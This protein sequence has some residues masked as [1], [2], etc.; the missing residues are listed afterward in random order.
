MRMSRSPVLAR[1]GMI[2]T[3]H[4]L[5]SATGLEVLAG[6]GNAIDAAVAAAAVLGVVQP[7]MSGLGGDTFMLVYRRHEDRTWGLN[8]SGPAPAGA[9]RESFIERGHM[10]MPLRGMLAPSVPGAVA[11]MQTALARW[12]SGHFTF[13]RLLDPAIRYAEE[14]APVARRVAHWM[15]EAAPVLARYPSSATIFLPGG[16]RRGVLPRPHRAGDRG[17]Q[18]QPRRFAL[19]R[20]LRRVRCGGL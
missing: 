11:A 17:V 4:A 16:R 13:Q 9:T 6:G 2:A 1:R 10:K 14:G 8:A 7:M 18:P 5:A 20:G 19:G 12:G 15:R 3:G